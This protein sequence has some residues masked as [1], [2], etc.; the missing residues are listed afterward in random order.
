M[1]TSPSRPTWNEP[2]V[3]LT[4]VPAQIRTE[5]V[6]FL[7]VPRFNMLSVIAMIDTLRVA[8]YLSPAALYSWEIVSFDGE[9]ITASNVRSEERSWG[10]R[11]SAPV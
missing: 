10:E 6:T 4:A 5:K 9:M 7:I 1:V 8:N 3:A 11:G 2:A